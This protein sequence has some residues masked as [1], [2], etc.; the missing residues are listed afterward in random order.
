VSVDAG[1]GDGAILVCTCERY[2]SL[3][4]FTAARLDAMWQPHPP[5]YFCGAGEGDARWL[6]LRDDPRD[7]MAITRRAVAALAE[8]GARWVYLVLDDHPPLGRCHGRHLNRDLPAWLDRLD[9]V[10]IGLNGY[11]QGKPRVGQI[12]PGDYGGLERLPE[13]FLWKFQLHPALW[14]VPGLIDLL[15]RLMAATEP[16][17][18]RSPW[19]F[20]RMAGAASGPAPASLRTRAYR[21]CGRRLSARRLH[22]VAH[23]GVRFCARVAR[24]VAGLA[25][26]ADAWKRVDEQVRFLFHYYDGPYPLFWAGA[27]TRGAPNPEY[28]RY[29]RYAGRRA[30]RKAFDRACAA[31]PTG[32]AG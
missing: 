13:D 9:A 2:R 24:Y 26:G 16:G 21:V 15:D 8:R 4:E 19:A 7:W 1:P 29:L 11:G 30:D 27:M 3:A 5:L 22:G 20:E 6:P 18:A 32:S 17:A 28:A 10:Y 14:S 31:I 23:G 12:V 25:G